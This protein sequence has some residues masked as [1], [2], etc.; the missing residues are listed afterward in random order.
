MD[1]LHDVITDS[2]TDALS[3]DPVE[4]VETA[5]AEDTSSDTVDTSSTS[6]SSSS[7][8][9]STET[10][11]IS[12]A[13]ASS[14]PAATAVTDG[15]TGGVTDEFDKRWGLQ[16][17]NIGGKE[18]RIPYSRVRKIIEKNEKDTRDKAKK[19]LEAEWTPKLTE[20][21]QKV[22]AYEQRLAQVGQFEQILEND[23]KQFLQMLSQVPAYKG[24]FDY[25][26][27]L[28][29]AGQATPAGGGVPAT[30][31]APVEADDPMPKPDAKYPDGSIGYSEEGLEKYM[32]WRERQIEKRLSG[33]V[34]QQLQHI[35]QQVQPLARNY[36]TEQY[37]AKLMPQIQSQVEEMRKWP[38]FVENEAEIVKV[39]GQNPRISPERAYQ[40]VV[41]PKMM[42]D[43]D[44]IRQEVMA[45]V[46]K[47]T[48]VPSTSVP[49][50]QVRPG[51]QKAGPQTLEDIIRR[52][53]EKLQNK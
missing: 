43:R 11:T 15:D 53:A 39:L 17:K 48:P 27:Q 45:E 5:S 1:D 50:R 51:P 49:S 42:A 9:D 37:I 10:E 25:I 44:R 20:A 33:R 12:D 29:K 4:T 41:H 3:D 21:T 22:Q 34:E 18:N 16:S 46:Q 2:L 52:E 7:S 13:G 32:Q 38:L 35:Q 47:A 24:F 26:G 23:P 28:S 8:S 36:Q 19:E 40:M 30:S 31:G 6:S 14:S